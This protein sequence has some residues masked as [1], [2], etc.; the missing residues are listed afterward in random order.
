MK[1]KSQNLMELKNR[2]R[3]KTR[4][5]GSMLKYSS[6]MA[7]NQ[8]AVSKVDETRKDFKDIL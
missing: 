3:K 7:G 5:S 1:S 8:E 6:N 2:G 4:I